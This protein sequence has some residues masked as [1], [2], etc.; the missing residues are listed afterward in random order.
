MSYGALQDY[1][2]DAYGNAQVQDDLWTVYKI[3]FA[4][5]QIQDLRHLYKVIQSKKLNDCIGSDPLV[6]QSDAWKRVKEAGGIKTL[7]MSLYDD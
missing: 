1:G 7:F 4:G 5:K 6:S 3:F 2:L